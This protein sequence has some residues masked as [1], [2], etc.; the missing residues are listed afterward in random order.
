MT[1]HLVKDSQGIREAR[2]HEQKPREARDFRN[3]NQ[4][5]IIMKI[6]LI[7]LKIRK[8]YLYCSTMKQKDGGKTE[9]RLRGIEN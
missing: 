2:H 7:I 6:A 9:V 1:R 8:H 3:R 5:I 4:P